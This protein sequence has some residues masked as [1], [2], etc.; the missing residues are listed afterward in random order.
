M[1]IAVI[2]AG[3]AFS[4]L[5]TCAASFAAM[6]YITE[7]TASVLTLALAGIAVLL[8]VGLLSPLGGVIAD[9]F[10]RK[11]VMLLSD[12]AA[13][14][15]SAILALIV[16]IGQVSIPLLLLLLAI[17]SAASA[18]HA[19]AITATMPLMVPE[20]SLVRLNSLSQMLASA[21]SIGGPV[22]GIFLYTTIGFEAVLLLDTLCAVLACGCL[23]FIA[24]PAIDRTSAQSQSAW[25]DFV[26]GVSFLR[27]D[28]GLL[29]LVA[30]SVLA[31]LLFTP[32]GPLFPL[33][34]YDW[35]SGD[36]YQASLVEAVWGVGMIVGSVALFAWGGGRRLVRL[37]LISGFAVGLAIVGCGLLPPSGFVWFVVLG[38]VI[39]ISVSLFS[40]PVLPIMQKRIPEEKLGRV[41]SL[42]ITL[43]TLTGPLGLLVAGFGAQQLG[44]TRWF[45][46]AGALLCL[47]MIGVSFSK[48]IRSLDES[49]SI[50]AV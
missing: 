4:I 32:L 35:F 30:L 17:R 47:A 44:L 3:Q 36:G 40:G 11:A 20:R 7:S 12:G 49:T 27:R 16:V 23:L 9:R 8:P 41:T 18:F 13:G 19:P 5:S 45:I 37:I 39:A 14:A 25:R 10:S 2:W 48:A 33:M 22:L 21:S 43:S 46:V 34:T 26:E 15:M 50:R 38:G 31:M 1:L 42:F 6:W 28:R 29:G 24:V